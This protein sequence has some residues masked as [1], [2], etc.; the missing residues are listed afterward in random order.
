MFTKSLLFP[1]SL[2][3]WGSNLFPQAWTKICARRPAWTTFA[4]LDGLDEMTVWLA[5]LSAG[6]EGLPGH[7]GACLDG[8][9]PVRSDH[10]PGGQL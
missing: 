1:N 8:I 9:A 7:P 3:A 4:D 10:M 6:L 2:K 5:W